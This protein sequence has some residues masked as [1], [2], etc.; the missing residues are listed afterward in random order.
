MDIKKL[1]ET[2]KFTAGFKGTHHLELSFKVS[3]DE[4]LMEGLLHVLCIRPF[5][6]DIDHGANFELVY[7]PQ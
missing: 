4:W 5:V 6:F 3:S 7:N 2:R 1:R